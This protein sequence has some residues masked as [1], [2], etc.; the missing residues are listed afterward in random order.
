M[1]VGYA[2]RM[3]FQMNREKPSYV[4]GIHSVRAILEYSP[5]RAI[6]LFYNAGSDNDDIVH[7]A[8]SLRLP[9]HACSRQD[10][11]QKNQEDTQHQGVLLQ[12]KP[13]SY[14]SLE[15]VL[16]Q[17]PTLI[18]VVDEIQDPRNLGR[19][20]RS[21]FALG[22]DALIISKDR[23]CS[24]TPTTEKS[25]TG[26]LAQLPVVQTSGLN[27]VLKELKKQGFWV[28][29]SSDKA[30]APVWD[31]K[32]TD[33][34]VL[35]VGNEEKGMRRVISDACDELVS[36]PMKEDGF[37]LNAADAACVLLY[38]INRQRALHKISK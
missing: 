28:I 31:C 25:A 4:G 13:F 12:V 15:E 30:S 11:T 37:S 27:Q 6:S 8:K 21:S 20:A 3:K 22:A 17:K 7:L 36:I 29:G 16:Q 26:A 23:S 1:T 9:L 19:C 18:V 33:P 32:L 34:M 10:L 5:K 2:M 38:E 35:I 24:I 14:K